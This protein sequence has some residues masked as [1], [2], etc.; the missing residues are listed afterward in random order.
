MFENRQNPVELFKMGV[1]HINANQFEKAIYCFD[2]AIKLEPN[3]SAF[4]L[5]KAA[6][7]QK[8]DR[9]KE[10]IIC[11]DKAIMIDPADDKN[12]LKTKAQAL[13]TKGEILYKQAGLFNDAI[14]CV[15]ES[16]RINP[17]NADAWKSRGMM[18][19]ESKEFE[20]A[21]HCFN[22]ALELD[23]NATDIWIVKAILEDHVG[24]FDEAIF[25]YK[26]FLE[27]ATR[28]YGEQVELARNRLQELQER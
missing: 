16:L 13:Y 27:K 2:E 8:L 28:E 15:D 24:R 7:Y 9:I 21:I 11:L 6:C 10:A 5:N 1:S 17:S 18:L 23:S 20:K 25:A 3:I 26:R 14:Q 22:K 12:A 4:W 19:Y